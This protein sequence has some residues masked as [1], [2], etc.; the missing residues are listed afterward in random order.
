TAVTPTDQALR[1]DPARVRSIVA[2]PSAMPGSTMSATA[3]TD[4]RTVTVVCRRTV[5]IPF[6]AVL[7]HPDGLERTGVARARSRLLPPDEARPST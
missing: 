7:G 5:R 1:L 4:G 2:R 3:T 6:G